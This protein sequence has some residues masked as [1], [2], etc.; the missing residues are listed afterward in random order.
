[1]RTI[2]FLSALH[3]AA[4]LA[5]ISDPANELTSSRADDLVE[6]LNERF[7]EAWE[8]EWWPEW[9][10]TEL[11]RYRE[12]YLASKT[13][14]APGAA[15]VSE[16]WFP[17]TKKYYQA[18][19]STLGN[20]PATLS[21]TTWTTD[22]QY[23][24][25]VA[26]SWSASDWLTSTAYAV[27]DVVRR[28]ADNRCYHCHTAHTSA[29]SD[30]NI[31]NFGLLEPFRRTI[32]A[33]QVHNSG[34]WHTPIGQ[35]EGAYTN[36]PRIS[37]NNPQELDFSPV[38]LIDERGAAGSDG[39]FGL[40]TSHYLFAPDAPDQV[41]LRFRRPAPE[42]T[43]TAYA[44]ATS[45]AIND[46]V[47]Y[48]STGECY[49]AYA[50]STGNPPTDTSYWVKID[51]PRV[52]SGFVK[53]AVQSDVLT[54]QKQQR[55]AARILD[56]ADQELAAAAERALQMQKQYDTVDYAGFAQ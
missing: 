8:Y 34:A 13:Y 19:Q 48:G 49:R 41:W 40:T 47:Y 30:L 50:A 2:T 42:F 7:R 25:E 45:Y 29:G 33:D 26:P 24:R 31:S 37:T 35:I 20:A 17:A 27:G 28:P 38:E 18:V 56:Q 22:Q 53:R 55:R 21:G 1:M 51:F 4:R 43:L 36:D 39:A 15:A 3:G 54:D 11:R 32:A 6:Y 9:T 52:I 44:S 46:V 14:A 5:G 10:V 16:V 23:W 12:D